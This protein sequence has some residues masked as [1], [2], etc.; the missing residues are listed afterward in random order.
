MPEELYEHRLS[1]TA[2]GLAISA[3]RASLLPRVWVLLAMGIVVDRPVMNLLG[4]DRHITAK[5]W[6]KQSWDFLPEFMH[7]FAEKAWLGPLGL[8]A[9]LFKLFQARSPLDILMS[10]IGIG[11][12]I[13]LW[14]IIGGAICRIAISRMANR[15][16]PGVKSSI[17]F[18][19]QHKTI[20]LGPFTAV[21]ITNLGMFLVILV[22]GLIQSIP[23]AGELLGW[24][25]VPVSIIL[26]VLIAISSVGLALGWPLIIG[27]AMAEA[28]DSFDAFSRSQAYL[29][30]APVSWLL[31]FKIGIIVQAVTWLIVHKM[32][33]LVS[34]ILLAGNSGFQA[35]LYPFN[36][37][38]P[39]PWNLPNISSDP[40]LSW[41]S[42]IACLAS[43]WPVAFEFAFAGAMYLTLRQRV[44]GISPTII[45]SSGQAEGSFYEE[46]PEF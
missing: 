8:V 22:L 10:L 9:P 27:A 20:I 31:T 24:V 5:A 39:A 40:T 25:S 43:C 44:D 30:Q 32:T 38:L 41:V 18:A 12:T 6:T 19:W 45:F 14:G 37:T 42:A 16:I 17:E 13:L 33:W 3:V 15:P 1:Q 21:C 4:I 11:F 26:S 36:S 7:D 29:F 46:R 2:I 23:F 28:D 35:E 34:C